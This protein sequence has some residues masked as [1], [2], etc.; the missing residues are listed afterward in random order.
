MLIEAL[1]QSQMMSILNHNGFNAVDN[2]NWD[3]EGIERI[4]MSNG[5]IN[6]PLKLKKLYL[7][8]EVIR[9][10]EDLRITIDNIPEEIKEEFKGCFAKYQTF[11]GMIEPAEESD[12][13]DDTEDQED[14]K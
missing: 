10:C 5:Q 12:D 1:S 14:N 6:F 9:R 2:E 11:T 13:A 7:F 8:P 4:I 3:T